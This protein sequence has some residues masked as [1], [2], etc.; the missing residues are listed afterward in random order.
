MDWELLAA[1]LREE[2]RDWSQVDL[3]RAVGLKQSTVSQYLGGKKHPSLASLTR[4]A[5]VLESSVDHLLGIEP[6]P[7]QAA[8]LVVREGMVEYL[9]EV[10]SEHEEFVAINGRRCVPVPH[11]RDPVAAG[12]SILNRTAIGE[13]H[14]LEVA[15]LRRLVR[16]PLRPRRL[17]MVDVHADWLGTSMADT[18]MPGATL[19]VDFGPDPAGLASFEPGHVYLVR[20]QRG[21]TCKRVWLTGDVLNLHADNKQ[22]EPLVIPLDGGSPTDHLIAKVICIANP[23]P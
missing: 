20:Y 1:R 21:V 22:V 3:A 8:S 6:I 13:V 16:G 9:C 11:L 19:I 18:I 2:A 12:W 5:A 14:Y 4:F 23:A 7:S 15:F 17:V 10:T